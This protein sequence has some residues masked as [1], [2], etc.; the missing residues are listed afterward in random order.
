MFQ[1]ET[2][3]KKNNYTLTHTQANR[4]EKQNKT[5]QNIEAEKKFEGDSGKER[6]RF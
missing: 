4:G 5:K 3:P 1:T 2:N 6:R